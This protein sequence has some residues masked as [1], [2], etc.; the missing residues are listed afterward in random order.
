M[1]SH[2]K[3]VNESTHQMNLFLVLFSSLFVGISLDVSMK[4]V[5]KLIYLSKVC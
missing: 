1:N 4:L 3:V 2:L 5:I